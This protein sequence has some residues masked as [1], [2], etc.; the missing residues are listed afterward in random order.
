MPEGQLR[1]EIGPPA[2]EA[3]VAGVTGTAEAGI[4]TEVDGIAHR[5]VVEPLEAA[6]LPG[7]LVQKIE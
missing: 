2:A 1:Q 6:A 3:A 4:G 5:A 7:L